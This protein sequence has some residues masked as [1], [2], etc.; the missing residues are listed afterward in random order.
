MLRELMDG[1]SAVRYD[2][3]K[4]TSS[5][6]ASQVERTIEKMII[7]E[8]KINE[9]IDRL[10][11]LKTE[12]RTEIGKVQN[13]TEQLILRLRYVQFKSWPVIQRVLGVS[14]RRVFALHHE[15]LNHFMVP[16]TFFD[17]KN[18]FG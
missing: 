1:L 11:E 6:Q 10:V 15:A 8:H 2:E 9:E 18:F 12:I 5:M 17:R 3:D 13:Q 16:D 7:L 14:E 4:V